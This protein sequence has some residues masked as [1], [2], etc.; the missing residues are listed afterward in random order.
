MFRILHKIIFSFLLISCLLS[1]QSSQS[2]ADADYRIQLDK[3]EEMVLKLEAINP[4]SAIKIAIKGVFLAEAQGDKRVEAAMLGRIGAIYFKKNNFVPAIEFYLRAYPIAKTSGDS[5]LTG[6]LLIDIGNSHYQQG[7][8]KEAITFYEK[9]LEVF[10]GDFFK[11]GRSVAFNNIGLCELKTGN[12]DLAEKYFNEGLSIRKTMNSNTLVLH[13]YGYLLDVKREK[14][15]FAGGDEL[16]GISL[17]LMD[18][19]NFPYP[20]DMEIPI[21]FY[22]KAGL[23]AYEKKEYDGAIRYYI[24]ALEKNRVTLKEN[25]LNARITINMAM[26]Y[27]GLGRS[28]EYVKYL[29]QGLEYAKKVDNTKMIKEAYRLLSGHYA[30]TGDYLNALR[31]SNKMLTLVE[32]E[33]ES[34]V[35]NRLFDLLLYVNTYDKETQLRLNQLELEKETEKKQSAEQRNYFLALV[36]ILVSG[37]LAVLFFNYRRAKKLNRDLGERNERISQQHTE[38]EKQKTAIEEMLRKLQQSNKSRDKFYSVFVH[39]I[40][41]P[42]HSLVACAEIL[43]KESDDISAEEKLDFN[44]YVLDLSTKV[45]TLMLEMLEWL[46]IQLGKTPVEI[47]PL[48]SRSFIDASIERVKQA[49]LNKNISIVNNTDPDLKVEADL[50]S[51]TSIFQNLIHNAIKFSFPGST[52][53]LGSEVE[54]G[55]VSFFV[56]DNGVGFTKSKMEKFSNDDMVTSSEG[57]E[58]E[59]G[60]GFGLIII[61]DMLKLN[62][63]KISLESEEGKGSKFTVTL[64]KAAAS[65]QES[66]VL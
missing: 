42:L 31:F 47:T 33:N 8:Y 21:E 24:L 16:L 9:S 61:K 49:A 15:D 28:L 13:S 14:R 40:K 29:N 59:P 55:T 65:S 63:A 66:F 7:L 44:R 52:V 17:P 41:N 35:K 53:E 48:E 25:N 58:K 36:V 51:M 57:T 27:K 38:I 37:L 34:A 22:Q 39:D 64:N 19:L 32:R 4:D 3:V 1:G 54:N 26:A 11:M 12:F 45:N 6:Y 23:F 60:T 56:K 50:T 2:L 20:G 10:T 18:S 5:N 43:V 30:S 62:N 46:G